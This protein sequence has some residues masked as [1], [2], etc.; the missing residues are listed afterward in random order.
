MFTQK[1]HTLNMYEWFNYSML[2]PLSPIH[3]PEASIAPLPLS[4]RSVS[5]LGGQCKVQFII[6]HRLPPVLILHIYNDFQILCVENVSCTYSLFTVL[7]ILLP[8]LII[9]CGCC[10]GK[11]FSAIFQSLDFFYLYTER[12][13]FQKFTHGDHF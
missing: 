7:A 6:T 11:M 13:F 4:L 8:V 2:H 10:E 9:K 3:I 5:D 1:L 12:A